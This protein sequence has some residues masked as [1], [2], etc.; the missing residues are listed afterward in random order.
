MRLYDSINRYE[1]I[2][3]GKSSGSF[4]VIKHQLGELG[5]WTA[6]SAA[7]QVTEPTS[8]KPQS[9]AGRS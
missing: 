2:N 4:L 3:G 9:R 7:A 1:L 8:S 5:S 6:R